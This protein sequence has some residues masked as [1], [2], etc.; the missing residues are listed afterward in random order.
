MSLKSGHC[1]QNS[2]NLLCIRGWKKPLKSWR[3]KIKTLYLA[4]YDQGQGRH[5]FSFGWT[6]LVRP[7][8]KWG[9]RW[10]NEAASTVYSWSKNMQAPGP[11]QKATPLKSSLLFAR[12]WWVRVC[13]QQSRHCV[14]L[15]SSCWSINNAG[16]IFFFFFSCKLWAFTTLCSRKQRMELLGLHSDACVSHGNLLTKINRDKLMEQ[17]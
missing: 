5:F 13:S 11:W 3:N 15:V 2:V 10:L 14:F 8:Y 9:P 6:D 16:F 4:T 12:V 17:V 7:Q 1:K